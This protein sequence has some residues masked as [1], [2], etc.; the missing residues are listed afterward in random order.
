ML[1]G[2]IFVRNSYVVPSESFTQVDATHWTL[3]VSALGGGAYADVRDV[4]LFVP[5]AGLLPPGA[6]LALHVQAG[7]SGWEYRGA[8]GEAQP[9]DVL[10]TCWPR[11]EGGGQY[12]TAQVGVSVEPLAELATR[13]ATAVASKQEYARRVALDMFRFMQSFPTTP[14][15]DTLLIPAN[16][17]ELWLAK[18][19]TKV[20]SPLRHIAARLCVLTTRYAFCIR[21]VPKRSRLSVEDAGGTVVTSRSAACCALC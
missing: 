13:E 6:G 5:A 12:A 14:R 4:C 15:G 1:F 7:D 2:I 3:D 11:P 16:V 9:S 8:V 19:E 10:A 20:R 17:L 18:F 21:P